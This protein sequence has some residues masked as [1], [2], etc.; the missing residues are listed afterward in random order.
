MSREVIRPNFGEDVI[1]Q[2][3]CTPEGIQREGQYGIDYQYT[4]NGDSA[5]MW[6]PREARDAIL[7]SGATQG[8][9]IRIGKAKRG[10]QTLW[11]VE[12]VEDETRPQQRQQQNAPRGNAQ[13]SQAQAAP[14]TQRPGASSLAQAIC[15]ALDAAIAAQAYA[16]DRHGIDFQIDFGDVRSLAITLWIAA[17]KE[18][19]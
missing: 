17:Q 11:L 4:C 15:T 2:L 1:V 13:P 7:K 9:E 5:I 10:R 14:P 8:D 18:A 19:K 16:R 3:S 6:L 12:R